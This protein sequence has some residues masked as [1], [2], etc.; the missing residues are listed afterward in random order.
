MVVTDAGI[1]EWVQV[2]AV[3][4]T[5]GAA[6]WAYPLWVKT[7]K[8]KNM[9]QA[10][11]NDLNTDYKHFKNH[12]C[13]H[14]CGKNT[15]FLHVL[16]FTDS[17]QR[18]LLDAPSQKKFNRDKLRILIGKM[19]QDNK[20]FYKFDKL[21]SKDAQSKVKRYSK[22][23]RKKIRIWCQ[24]RHDYQKTIRETICEM[25]LKEQL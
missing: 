16:W 1:L 7:R 17:Y 11:E 6:A 12:T 14:N 9:L 25:L 19:K 23:K 10:C 24:R 2:S 8:V 21:P 15:E 18:V 5:L 3:P 4:I 13:I 22:K 20:L